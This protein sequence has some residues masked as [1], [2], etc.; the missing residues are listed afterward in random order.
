VPEDLRQKILKRDAST[1][2]IEVKAG[3]TDTGKLSADR[4]SKLLSATP[5]EEVNDPRIKKT[6]DDAVKGAK[7]KREE[8]AKLTSF[9]YGYVQN[10][11]LDRGYAPAVSTLESKTGDCTE[12]SVL[13]SALLRSRG[14]PTRL[15]DGVII[16]GTHAGYHEWVEAYVDGE[17][18]VPA[19]PTF[20]QFPAGPER[21]K[22]AEGSTMP[23]EHMQLSLAAARLLK[24]GVKIEVLESLPALLANPSPP[25]R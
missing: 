21:L 24:P 13:L 6:A 16:D 2:T 3:D 9:V 5:Y 20:N 18:F 10:K 1:I 4:R 8:V 12:H 19:D 25:R 15:I 11:S 23:D 22:L 17:G 7:S 14:I